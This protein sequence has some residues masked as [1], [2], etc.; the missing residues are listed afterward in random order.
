M[1]LTF[2]SMAKFPGPGRRVPQNVQF[3]PDGKFLCYLFPRD[4]SSVLEL[5]R[6][7]LETGEKTLWVTPPEST[8]STS[9]AEDLRRQRERIS[10]HGILSY[11]LVQDQLLI[12]YQGHTFLKRGEEPLERLEGL[13]GVSDLTLMPDL[14]GVLFV[15]QGNIGWMDLVSRETKMLTAGEGVTYG[16]AEYVAQ[17]ELDRSRGYWVS[18]DSAWIA[19]A[20]VDDSQV[21]IFPIVHEESSEVSLEEHRYPFVGQANAQVRIG[22]M[23]ALGGN[24]TW[25]AGD[26]P[27]AY[28][29]DVVWMKAGRVAVLWLSRDHRRLSWSSYD[30]VSGEGVEIYRETSERWLNLP[31]KSVALEDGDLLTT[32]ES[33]GHAHLVRIAPTGQARALDQGDWDVTKVVS[34]ARDGK[35]AFV[36]ATRL[37]AL[38]RTLLRVDLKDG[39]VTEMT[40][41]PGFHDAMVSSFD[42]AFVDFHSTFEHAPRVTWHPKDGGKPKILFE[43]S[44]MTQDA[45]GLIRPE[46]VTVEASDGTP[47]NGILY[48]P[49]VID[50][51]LPVVVSVYGGPHAQM[52]VHSWDETTDLQAQ[53]LAQKGFLVFKLDGRG[54]AHRGTAFEQALFHRFGTVELEDQLTGVKWL[55]QHEAVN[56]ERV[57]I[58]GWSYGGYM[59][60]RAMLEAPEVFKVGVSGAP[61]TDFR[62]YDTAYTE[63]YMGV[64]ETNHEGYE[65]ASVVSRAERL[66][67]KLLLIH[68]LVDENVHFRHS[69][70]LIEAL[71]AADRDF[72]LL[73]LPGSRHMPVDPKT[74]VYRLRRTLQYFEQHL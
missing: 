31:M 41:E 55:T 73:V 68:G 1:E 51:P 34:V 74:K 17:E 50:G 42:G 11:Q 10:W 25:L 23:P 39:R 30:P 65:V 43:E 49:A 36:M 70:R 27:E 47:L 6:T 13:D 45:L 71:I 19:L 4:E 3:S 72:D 24:I 26:E 7:R 22:V 64:D 32:S 63:R 8:S 54:S 40:P 5:W 29:G 18:P 44:G 21:P 12:P 52:V 35:T 38:E 48:R 33:S 58:H 69:V 37:R 9:L 57:G 67:G 46:L 15:R 53:Y 14:S 56:P 66:R 28:V 2:D 16:L 61:V 60:V 20:E 62:W 59:T